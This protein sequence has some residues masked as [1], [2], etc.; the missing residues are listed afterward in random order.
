MLLGST[1]LILSPTNEFL[2]NTQ[3]KTLLK[4]SYITQ[5]LHTCKKYTLIMTN[6]TRDEL[7]WAASKF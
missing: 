5:K 1:S 2:E 6:L 3:K 4:S 7:N